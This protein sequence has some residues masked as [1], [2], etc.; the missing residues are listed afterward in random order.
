M[1]SPFNLTGNRT[2]NPGSVSPIFYAMSNRPKGK[3]HT[4]T[5][6]LRERNTAIQTVS[7]DVVKAVLTHTTNLP[8]SEN[9]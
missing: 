9:Q 5:R 4:H 6:T 2:L 8:Y 7:S 1:L 3:T